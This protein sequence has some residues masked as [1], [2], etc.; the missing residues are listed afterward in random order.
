MWEP[1]LGSQVFLNS[2]CTLNC[3]FRHV[4]VE[5]STF[6]VITLNRMKC[7]SSFSHLTSVKKQV[8]PA[9]ACAFSQV[10]KQ[11]NPIQWCLRGRHSHLFCS[12]IFPNPL[13]F[14][15]LVGSLSL[16]LRLAPSFIN[17]IKHSQPGVFVW[18]NWIFLV[19]CRHSWLKETLNAVLCL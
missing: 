5:Q 1:S 6:K 2:P 18:G 3:M 8:T 11:C 19:K 17:H 9:L 7:S 12:P 14:P 13:F 10:Q 15:P 4:L 16:F